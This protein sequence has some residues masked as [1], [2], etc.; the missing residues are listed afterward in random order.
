MKKLIIS[1][2]VLCALALGGASKADAHPGLLCHG[3]KDCH[4]LN[5]ECV[6]SHPND[7]V[8]VCVKFDV[9]NTTVDCASG[10]ICVKNLCK[11]YT[12]LG[13]T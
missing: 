7:S 1:A 8:G 3:G 13:D 5:E 10:S 12:M 6:T 2:V 9:C 4:N 11:W